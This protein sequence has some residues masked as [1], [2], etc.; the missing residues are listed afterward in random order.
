MLV[1]LVGGCV[2]AKNVTPGSAMWTL[3]GDRTV[4]TTVV[5]VTAV[6]ARAAVDVVTEH[7]TFSASPDLLPATPDGWTHAVDAHLVREPR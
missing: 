4:R 2:Q 5:D 1:N 3:D 7:M 6:K